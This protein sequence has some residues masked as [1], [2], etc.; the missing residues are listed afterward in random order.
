LK[1]QAVRSSRKE[2]L[3]EN[4]QR[5]HSAATDAIKAEIERQ[6]LSCYR[7]AKD[8]GISP[9][10]LSRFSQPGGTLKPQSLFVLLDYLGVDLVARDGN[11]RDGVDRTLYRAKGR[12]R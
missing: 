12:P 8:T 2:D 5:I 4:A 1:R 7:I 3:E 6:G 10:A 9:A 11:P